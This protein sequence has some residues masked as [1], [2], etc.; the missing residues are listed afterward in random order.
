MGDLLTS[1]GGSSDENSI[2]Q[3]PSS[4]ITSVAARNGGLK[5][6]IWMIINFW[7]YDVFCNVF[8]VELR[9]WIIKHY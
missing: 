9:L 2:A 8:E 7:Y 4:S 6:S 3:D 5:G 1:G